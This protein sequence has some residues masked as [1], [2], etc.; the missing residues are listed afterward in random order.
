MTDQEKCVGCDLDL[1]VGD[2]VFNEYGIGG[3]VHADCCG[4]EREGY[5]NADGDPLGPDEPLPQ[6]FAWKDLD[7]LSP[8]KGDT[9]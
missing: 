6:P 8:C 7:N 9:L 2:L 5:V 3:F 4:P 1:K